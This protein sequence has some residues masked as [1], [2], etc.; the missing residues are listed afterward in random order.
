MSKLSPSTI[1]TLKKLPLTS[2]HHTHASGTFLMLFASERLYETVCSHLSSRNVLNPD[3]LV[4]KSFTNE[5]VNKTDVHCMSMGYRI[6]CECDGTLVVR[7][8]IGRRFFHRVI[9]V[10]VTK[11]C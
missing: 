3:D 1:G 9:A 2:R 6:L 10:R 4:M 8:K 7:E 11:F 5:M